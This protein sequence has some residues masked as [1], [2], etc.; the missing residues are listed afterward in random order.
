MSTDQIL[1]P[2]APSQPDAMIKTSSS[3]PQPPHSGQRAILK[4]KPVKKPT[5]TMEQSTIADLKL[6]RDVMA[7]QISTLIASNSLLTNFLVTKSHRIRKANSIAGEIVR[8]LHQY[9]EVQSLLNSDELLTITGFQEI[10]NPLLAKWAQ[11]STENE[12][13]F[14]KTNVCKLNSKLPRARPIFALSNL[15]SYLTPSDKKHSYFVSEKLSNLIYKIDT[16]L[17]QD[18]P[19][20]RYLR[21]GHGY[22]TVWEAYLAITAT[23]Y[24]FNILKQNPVRYMSPYHFQAVI[25]YDDTQ[26]YAEAMKP[27]PADLDLT[28]SAMGAN[29]ERGDAEFFRVQPLQPSATAPARKRHRD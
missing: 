18:I 4:A 13:Y 27:N 6:S 29:L 21:D 11:S 19:Q 3:S 25:D 9:N 23:I 7:R 8:N 16:D 2:P 12:M 10:L 22:S 1:P 20:H 5:T 15:I 24:A 28:K 14:Y 26:L 17:H